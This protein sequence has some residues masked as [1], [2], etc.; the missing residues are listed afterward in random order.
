MIVVVVDDDGEF[1]A[2]VAALFLSCDDGIDASH[3]WHGSE[4]RI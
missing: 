1:G 4:L 2:C 3:G